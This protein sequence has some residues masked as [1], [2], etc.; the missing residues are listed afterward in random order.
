[1]NAVIRHDGAMA[2]IKEV[3][4]VTGTMPLLPHLNQRTTR[5]R[6]G[7]DSFAPLTL[8]ELD[9]EGL[10][11]RHDTKYVFHESVLTR[12]L[13]ELVPWC[14]VLDINGRRAF[15]YDSLYLDTADRYLYRCHHQGHIRRTKVRWRVY[16][17]SGRCYFEVKRKE[18]SDMTVK[19]RL[20]D[21]LGPQAVLSVRHRA[22]LG[23]QILLPLNPVMWVRY[24]R[25]TLL[26]HDRST[27]LTIDTNLEFLQEG[28]SRAFPGLVI[29]EIKTHAVRPRGPIAGLLARHHVRPMSFSKYCAGLAAL[30]PVPSQFMRPVIRHV[31]RISDHVTVR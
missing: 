19:T 21:P 12:M 20:E 17:D 14:R 3:S 8:A 26:A 28:A 23:T 29:A 13:E 4:G 9:S 2:Q 10:L 7:L 1:M 5:P 11:A 25:I 18:T 24:D 16:R 22:L 27:K 6:S 30:E 31:E 15:G